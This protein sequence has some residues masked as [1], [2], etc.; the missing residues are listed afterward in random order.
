L[1]LDGRGVTTTRAANEHAGDAACTVS[2]KACDLYQ[3]MWH[4][5]DADE[6]TVTGERAVLQQF[7]EGV[8]I[9]WS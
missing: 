8:Q 3:A 1:R 4:R 2:G 6:L 9:R 7:S 5:A